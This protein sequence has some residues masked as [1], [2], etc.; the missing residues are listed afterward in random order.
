MRKLLLL[1]LIMLICFPVIAEAETDLKTDM[2][3]TTI[4]LEDID[5][6]AGTLITTIRVA[7]LIILAPLVISIGMILFTA[8]DSYALEQ[9]K[10]RLIFIFVGIMLVFTTE[11]IVRFIYSIIK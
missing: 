6:M 1:L 5:N 9:V 4:I 10:G 8:K 11:P 3:D 2:F 7:I